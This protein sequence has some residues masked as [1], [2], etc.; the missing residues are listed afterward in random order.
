MLV[1]LFVVC[2]VLLIRDCGVYC[3]F[4]DLMFWFAGIGWH[5]LVIA[6]VVLMLIAVDF[7]CFG[8]FTCLI[9]WWF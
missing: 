5:P 9:D 7:N 1:H 3:L 6:L 8:F 2:L 4:I